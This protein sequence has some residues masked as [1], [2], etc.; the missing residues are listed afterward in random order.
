MKYQK[1]TTELK[2]QKWCEGLC[3]LQDLQLRRCYKPKDFGE[4]QHVELHHFMD[5][6]LLGYGECSY[7]RLIKENGQI[8]CSLVMAKS[9]V[10]PSKQMTVPRLELTAAVLAAKVS[11]FLDNE[12]DYTN[13]KHYY[14]TDSKVVHQQRRTSISYVCVQQSAANPGND[15]QAPVELH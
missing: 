3:S 6:S 15:R 1:N 2:W 5:A 4:P 9:R 7:L 8:A 13:I 11:V 10:T 12:L 14:W